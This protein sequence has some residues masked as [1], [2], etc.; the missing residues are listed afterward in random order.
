M[1]YHWLNKQNNDKLI[2]FFAGWSFDFKPFEFLVQDDYDILTV[3]D[4]SN[5]NFKFSKDEFSKYNQKFLI[6]WSMGVYSAYCIKDILPDFDKKIAINGTVYP[7]DNEFGIPE[8]PF[9]LTLRH[10]KKGLEEKF[11]K[12]IF[13]NSDEYEKYIKNPVERS[14]E[15]RVLELESLYQNISCRKKTYERFYDTAFVSSNDK[16][17]PSNNQINFW[18]T[19]DT[20]YK[21]LDSGHFPYYNFCSWKELL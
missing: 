1:Q 15:N 13:K 6:T 3:Y 18:K 19:Y 12:N 8:K 2:I 14:I 7:V 11:Y 4:Y 9:L 16:I 17:V 10:A 5:M 20:E 21:V